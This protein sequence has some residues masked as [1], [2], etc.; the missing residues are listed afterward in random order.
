MNAESRHSI[1]SLLRHQRPLMLKDA[2]V[3]RTVAVEDYKTYIVEPSSSK[4]KAKRKLANGEST[5]KRPLE[6]YVRSKSSILRSQQPLSDRNI[7]NFKAAAFGRATKP[8]IGSSVQVKVGLIGSQG[9]I[10]QTVQGIG[11]VAVPGDFSDIRSPIRS[12]IYA[13]LTPG[14]GGGRR[15]IPGTTRGYRCPAGFEFGG[16]FTDRNY[17]TCGAQLFE[18]PM[19]GQAIGAAVRGRGSRPAVAAA[20]AENISEVVQAGDPRS[21]A[22]QI[23][24]MAQIPRSGAENSK[25]R[26]NAT[27][28]A[29]RSLTGAPSGES[30]MIRKDGIMLR[31]VVPSSVLRN[32]G[33]NPDMENGVFVRSIAQPSD[34][35]GD[36]LALL[37]GPAI[38]QVSYVTPNGS[39][40][41]I[42]RQRDLTVGERRKFGRQLNQAAGESDQYD[43]G[44]N[45]RDFANGSGGAFKYS[46]KFPNV[47]KPLDLI[48]VE[49]ASGKKRT[50]RRWVYETFMKD[51]GKGRGSAPVEK[52]TL[53]EDN[54]NITDAPSTPADALKFI[55]EGGDPFDLAP[56][57]ISDA[58]RKSKKYESRKLGTGITRYSDGGGGIIYQ[59]P[60]S[61]KNGSI[62]ERYYSDVG[63]QLGLKTPAARLVGEDGNREVIIGDPSND[64]GRVDSDLTLDDVEAPDVL[65]AVFAD[66]LTDARDRSPATLQAVRTQQ[67]VTV[68]P[69]SNELSALA[70]LSRSDIDKRF[71]LDLPD[72]LNT[73]QSEVFKNRFSKMNA[74][75]RNEVLSVYDTLIDRA[76]KFDWDEYAS[77]IAADGNLSKAEQAHLEILKKLF[78][79]R[80][81]ILVKKKKQT[82][83]LLGI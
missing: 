17:S 39:I 38:R 12:R 2:R 59:I 70:G 6:P 3:K 21:R 27:S 32:F 31:P 7:I 44:N 15:G 25:A 80:L 8:R 63:S 66:F 41:T 43:V 18:I 42:E 22:L 33:G 53:R 71:K 81:D 61:R 62:A 16:R 76:K 19:L 35:V 55:D 9:R 82:I 29:I 68:V 78:N 64:G 26:A 10:G 11:S 46:E 69:S 83:Q 20:R 49:D 48:E 4:S 36:D 65:R 50:V 58:L 51:K 73:R 75:E 34:I 67:G 74:K 72:Y 79:E 24:R 14:G 28:Q 5:T 37:A 1:K 56:N 23:S 40:L 13:A 60:E 30:R 57:L 45:I 54:V 52:R 77:R 47:P